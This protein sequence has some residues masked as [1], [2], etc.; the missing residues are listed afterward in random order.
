MSGGYKHAQAG[1]GICFMTLPKDFK[2]FKPVNTG[3]F[4]AFGDLD[5]GN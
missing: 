1:E 4:T 3:W 5:K 2:K